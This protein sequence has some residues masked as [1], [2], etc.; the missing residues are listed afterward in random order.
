MS[1]SYGQAIKKFKLKERFCYEPSFPEQWCIYKEEFLIVCHPNMLP[2]F[3]D[4][5]G[6]ITELKCPIP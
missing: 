6:I 3:I 4:K 2:K 5:F 1:I